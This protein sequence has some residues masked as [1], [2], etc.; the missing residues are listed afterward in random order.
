MAATILQAIVEHFGTSAPLQATFPGG[1]W[2]EFA[3]EGVVKP[4]LLLR[5]HEETVEFFT[6]DPGDDSYLEKTTLTLR[7]VGAGLVETDDAAQVVKREYDWQEAQVPLEGGSATAAIGNRRLSYRLSALDKVSGGQPVC[8]G[9]V[10][11]E[12]WVQDR[13]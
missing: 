6:A 3:P 4:Y 11:F 8:L 9:D 2:P 5:D 12:F 13:H 1:F 7:A 10:R